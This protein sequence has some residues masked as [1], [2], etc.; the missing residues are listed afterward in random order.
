M[1]RDAGHVR[2][3]PLPLPGATCAP[4]GRAS[5]K[6]FVPVVV[7]LLAAAMDAAAATPS[8][9]PYAGEQARSIKALSEAEIAGLLAGKGMGL[10]K[11]AELNGYPGPMHVLELAEPLGLSQQQVRATRSVHAAMRAQAQDIGARLVDAE[12]GLEQLFQSGSATA[13]ALEAALQSIGALQVRLRAVHL[14]AHI[15]QRALLSDEQV[16]AYIRLRGY[17]DGGHHAQGSAHHGNGAGH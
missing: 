5:V 7:L 10:A 15:D 11:P 13:D 6:R 4:P 12:A 14:Q 16:H 9:S 3:M 17:G 8:T 2:S 1:R